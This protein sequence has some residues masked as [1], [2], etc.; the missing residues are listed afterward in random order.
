MNQQICPPKKGWIR[1]SFKNEQPYR[2]YRL[3][4]TSGHS[5]EGIGREFVSLGDLVL[6]HSK[7]EAPWKG[8]LIGWL[9]G[10]FVLIAGN[11]LPPLKGVSL[12][13]LSETKYFRD[14]ASRLKESLAW[15]ATGRH[16]EGQYGKEIFFLALV[17][18]CYLIP[19]KD[20]LITQRKTF[21]SDAVTDYGA[22][23]CFI[24]S[25]WNGYWPLWNPYLHAGEPLYYDW[26]RLTLLDPSILLSTMCLKLFHLSIY[27]TFHYI[28]ILRT[29][30]LVL[31]AY[32]LFR[33]IFT[34][35]LSTFI[36]LLILLL[37]DMTS[38]SFSNHFYLDSFLWFPW[39]M[40][41]IVR[42]VEGGGVREI[43]FIAFLVGI[44]SAIRYQFPLMLLA[45][46]VF[47][48]TMLIN[49][50]E[51]VM[52]ALHRQKSLHL[53][54]CLLLMVGLC[55][56]VPSLLWEINKI[57]RFSPRGDV[58]RPLVAEKTN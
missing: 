14:V 2:Y 42:L 19:L 30:I 21:C 45:L 54:L 43:A 12:A 34:Y 11:S 28:Y 32:F 38:L 22:Y 25:L 44:S 39:I 16:S 27:A 57:H 10:I 7:P 6:A 46:T 53:G 41:F 55:T 50:K 20:L 47:T 29:L 37:G 15:L 33:R 24:E 1:W 49:H 23:H 8:L 18:L 17:L 9:A 5:G 56:P 4:I 51:R 40:Y 36:S 48:G 13:G 31:G 26:V 3:W 58:P 52:G 35:A